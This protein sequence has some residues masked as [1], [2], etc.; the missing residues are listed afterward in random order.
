[1]GGKYSCQICSFHENRISGQCSFPS[2]SLLHRVC[3]LVNISHGPCYATFVTLKRLQHHC[4][5]DALCGEE[6]RD[7]HSVF[8]LLITCFSSQARLCS[9]IVGRLIWPVALNKNKHGSDLHVSV[10]FIKIILDK[11]KFVISLKKKK[12]IDCTLM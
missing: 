12:K 10:L 3:S 11:Y 1:M 7:L 5:A 4:G 8:L 9:E 6:A 2:L